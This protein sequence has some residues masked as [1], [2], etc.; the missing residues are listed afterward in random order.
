MDTVAHE[1]LIR[2]WQ[3]ELDLRFTRAAHKTVL[4]SAR[5][6]GPLAVQRPF[7]PE[8]DVCHLY[9]LHPPGGIVGGDELHISVTLDAHSHALITQPGA[10][11]FYRSAGQLAQLRQDFAL[12]PHAT[13]EW[14][15]QDTILFPGARASLRTV[16]H[17]TTESQLLGWDLLCL[18]RPVMQET[19]SHGTLVNR[20]EI[21]R[22]GIPL[23]IEG[24]KIRG[25][26]LS[27]VANQPWCGTL[28]CYP[29]TE[30][31]LDGARERLMPLGE[32]AGATLVDSLLTVRFLAADN[33]LIQRAMRDIWRFLRPLL[34]HK[35]PH[36]PRIWQT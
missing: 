11:K 18:G 20:L 1:T 33:L 27:A 3:A 19:F 7:Y 13:L 35:Q 30:A 36:L 25:G 22:D 5:H 32:Y 10:G 14:L 24:L 26:D 28:F 2:G 6:V 12:A 15:P 9:L 23:L 29:G 8:D 17:L 4:T 34:T 21:W 16:F 31:M